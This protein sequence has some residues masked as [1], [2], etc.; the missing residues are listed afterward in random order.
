MPKRL[1]A[2]FI[3]ALLC[4]PQMGFAL[5]SVTREAG[6]VDKMDGGTLALSNKNVSVTR[7][8]A[9]N[10]AV[11][12]DDGGYLIYRCNEEI[13]SVSISV[14]GNGE[15]AAYLSEDNKDYQE[16]LL[17]R[18]GNIYTVKSPASDCN[19]LKIEFQSPLA[20]KEVAVN[21]NTGLAQGGSEGNDTARLTNLAE[22]RKNVRVPSKDTV[23]SI[24][25][26]KNPNLEHPRILAR[27]DDWERIRNDLEHDQ[28]LQKWYSVV[29]R[30]SNGLLNEPPVKYEI[31]DG[32]RL[33][34]VSRVVKRRIENLGVAWKL[35]GDTK[36]AERAY[37]ELLAAARFPNW[38]PSHFLDVGEMSWAFA[39]GYDWLYDYLDD[40]QKKIVREALYTHGLLAA[41]TIMKTRTGFSQDFSNW[42]GVCSGGIGVAALA[43]GDEYLHLAPEL[44]SIAIES[45]P[46]CLAATYPDGGYPEGPGY[47]GYGTVYAAY[48]VAALDSA[49]GDDFGVPSVEG[50]SE[51]GYFPL[52]VQSSGG[53]FNFADGVSG[54]LRGEQLFW[55]AKKFDQPIVAWYQRNSTSGGPLDIVFYDPEYCATPAEVPIPLDKYFRGSTSLATFRS[56][57]EDPGALFAGV[58]AGDNQQG[59]GHMDIGTF[60][61][62]ALGERW[63]VDL[64]PETY[65]TPGW[66]DHGNGRWNYYR[67]RAEAHNTIIINPSNR[68][69]QNPFAVDRIEKF[70]TE[71]SGGYAIIDMKNAYISNATSARRGL[72]L[73]DSR[74]KLL[75]QD[76]FK[77][78]ANN[79][80]LYW[81]MFTQAI[82]D[83]AEDG[84]S[85]MLTKGGKQVRVDLLSPEGAVFTQGPAE[86]LPTSP[87]PVEN[88]P[89]PGVNKLI[90]KLEGIKKGTL[91]VHLTP[92]SDELILDDPLPE[93]VPLDSWE[94]ADI[95]MTKLG[96]ITVDG[97]PVIGFNPNTYY[98][99]V[100]IPH[101]V[102]EILNVD[103]TEGLGSAKITQSEKVDGT[104]VI[105]VSPTDDN[106]RRTVY[107]VKFIRQSVSVIPADTPVFAIKDVQAS[108]VP[109]P[110]N[111][112]ANSYDG[113]KAT[114]WSADATVEDQWLVYDLGEQ[115][116]LGGVSVIWLN[117]D[118]R[119]SYF[120]VDVSSDKV[121]WTNVYS[122]QSSG[123]SADEESYLFPEQTARYLRITSS[124]TS[125]GKWVSVVEVSCL[126]AVDIKRDFNDIQGLPMQEQIRDLAQQGIVEGVSLINFEPHQDIT[127]ADFIKYM[128]KALSISESELNGAFA[129]AAD[130]GSAAIQLQEAAAVIDTV[131]KRKGIN[132]EAAEFIGGDTDSAAGIHRADAVV[133]IDALM[134]K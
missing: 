65:D 31:L 127:I 84:R 16:A 24:L 109:Q 27:A 69:D 118:Q 19:Y 72:M 22:I 90:V 66:G 75:V 113:D 121:N 107:R 61:F 81:H 14:V 125:V 78:K 108:S 74:S 35:S 54:S 32:K 39:L 120:G 67:H 46:I 116:R 128:S 36:Y 8:G 28:Y 21:T 44:I 41:E 52:Y 79:S 37:E 73:Y 58:K 68:P 10:M 48:F 43:I 91:A 9:V 70:V 2:V 96:G 129:G 114:R 133:I 7:Q 102:N 92:V 106:M 3:C 29:L 38:N 80:V 42:N 11:T 119:I 97:S 18:T 126:G 103:C 93:V 49:L 53:T 134:K 117:G 59:H 112:P 99:E 23:A 124:G 87:N 85:V 88:L 63:A 111:P 71:Q 123:E 15:I 130:R 20:I 13:F 33:L 64:G 5:P 4:V 83:I 82:I 26:E 76:E 57:W 62:D 12:G 25:L 6:L 30:T 51:T 100:Y 95:R 94:I 98:Y 40:E 89:N 101:G 77:L 115:Q 131:L 47:W 17:V 60:V 132:T 110:E 86:P 45:L 122:G 105:E 55:M 34:E 56:S 50:F 1:L 104:A